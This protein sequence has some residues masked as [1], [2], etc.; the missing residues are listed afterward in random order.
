MLN[1]SIDN[2]TGLSL[3]ITEIVFIPLKNK[4]TTKTTVAMGDRAPVKVP[5]HFL[6]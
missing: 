1:D 5:R 3:M 4:N 2:Q 6:Y